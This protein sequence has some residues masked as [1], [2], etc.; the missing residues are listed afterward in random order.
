MSELVTMQIYVIENRHAP[1][2]FVWAT[3]IAKAN[4]YGRRIYP[5]SPYN[6]R[7]T[8][9]YEWNYLNEQVILFAV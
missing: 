8:N 6:V 2:V 1:N 7:L 5:N 3:S 4:E 9:R